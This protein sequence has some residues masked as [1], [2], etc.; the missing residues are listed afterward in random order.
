MKLVKN[1]MLC[2]SIMMCCITMV[3]CGS[4]PSSTSDSVDVT[5]SAEHTS[6]SMNLIDEMDVDFYSCSIDD[7]FYYTILTVTNNSDKVVKFEANFTAKDDLGNDIGATTA[8]NK[9]IAPGQ[10]A[11]IWSTIDYAPNITSFDY[12]LTVDEDKDN[13]SIYNDVA[14]EYNSVDDKIL[15]TATNNGTDT[16]YYVWAQILFFKDGQLVNFSEPMFTDNDSELKAGAT[17]TQEAVCYSES[18]FDTV[19]VFISGRK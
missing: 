7:T 4:A 14:L 5:E 19:E 1:I 15:I 18:G 9:A 17:S 11:C 10:T 16:A 6:E 3:G 8:D 2:I 13:R 12:T